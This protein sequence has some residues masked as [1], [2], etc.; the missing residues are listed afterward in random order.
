LTTGVVRVDLGALARNYRIV[1]DVS[2]PA[3]C[4]AV[5]K[6]D[7][8]GLG[9][10][11]VA[12]RLWAEGCRKFFVATLSEGLELREILSDA[13][14][15]VFEGVPDGAADRCVAA[16]LTPV[17]NSLEQIERWSGRDAAAAVH[18]DTGI[19]RLGLSAAEVSALA[20]C[21]R[22]IEGLRI[23]YVMTHLACGDQ[24]DHALNA[25]Q[26]ERFAALRAQLPPAK[27][28][29][30]NSAGAFLGGPY[31]GDLVRPGIALYGGNP[32]CEP[33]S[34]VEPVV[35]VRGLILQVREVDEPVTVGYG[36]TYGAAPP[37]RL[38]VVGIGYADGYPRCLGNRGVASFEGVRVPVV[39][40]VSM[41]M[42]CID[43]G[44]LPRDAVSPG[45]FV[46]LF[47]TD[48]GIDEVAEAAGTISYE[49]LT[50]LGR[51]VERQY[52]S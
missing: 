31:R 3:E 40:R 46:E 41:D 10:A 52:L 16:G 33:P 39:G 7:A 23:D 50:R 34:P 21:K 51:R 6:A 2:A 30:A 5:V 38:A 18:I 20:A 11:P 45:A 48:V 35:S 13:A 44:R 47:G 49:L 22:L 15:Y 27:T 4:G 42:L 43:V 24:R 29:I 25:L 17:L 8:Y 12:A 32:F 36:A 19:S 1:R 9:V 14:I 28:S 37:A 26:L